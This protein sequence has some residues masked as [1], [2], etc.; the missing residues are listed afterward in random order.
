MEDRHRT[1]EVEHAVSE[2]ARHHD[3]P[4]P[5]RP[6][7]GRTDAAHCQTVVSRTRSQWLRPRRLP[8]GRGGAD[9]RAGSEPESEPALRAAPGA[10]HHAGAALGTGQNGMNGRPKESAST[11]Q[12]PIVGPWGWPPCQI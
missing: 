5:H 2:E 8:N 1:R 3:G 11:D 6:G 9:V 12:V 7:A 10:D 4:G